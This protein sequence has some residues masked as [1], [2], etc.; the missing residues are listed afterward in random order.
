MNDYQGA[1]LSYGGGVNS[2][3][4]TLRLVNDG[5]RGP[6]V[7]ADTSAERPSTYCHIAWMDEWL[8]TRGLHI[9]TIS[10]A[11][12][13]PTMLEIA[14]KTVHDKSLIVDRPTLEGFCLKHGLI[15]LEAVRWC[16]V[17]FK[18]VLL[19]AYRIEHGIEVTLQGIG[20]DEPTRVHYD[21]PTVRYPLV[22]WGWRRRDCI[23]YI[24]AQGIPI[25][26][27]S[28]CFFCPSP[29]LNVR[30]ELW[31]DHPELYERAAAMERNASLRNHKRATLD[32]R[33]IFTLDDLRQRFE[34]EGPMEGF[35]EPD[36]RAYEPCLCGL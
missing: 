12:A 23:E 27:K 31:K 18:R 35:D 34:A 19:E 33:G 2:C 28:S 8:K 24:T 5:W 29:H 7:F 4:M 10:W 22:D 1:L 14:S 3:S 13:T 15:P 32:P 36:M 25:P 17:N 11:T 9:E 6:I 30:R 26:P 16:S 20:S 21:D